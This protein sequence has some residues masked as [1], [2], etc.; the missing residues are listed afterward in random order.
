MFGLENADDTAMEG[1]VQAH[2]WPLQGPEW[3]LDYWLE[4]DFDVFVISSLD[5]ELHEVNSQIMR[6]FAKELVERCEIARKLEARKPLF[7]ETDVTILDCAGAR[8]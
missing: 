1:I 8:R 4:R 6:G 3:K 2:A 7:L 5:Y